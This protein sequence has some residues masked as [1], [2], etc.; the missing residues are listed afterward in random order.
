MSCGKNVKSTVWMRIIDY[1]LGRF[2]FFMNLRNVKIL[3]LRVDKIFWKIKKIEMI[4]ESTGK[5]WQNDFW[6][7]P[8]IV[9]NSAVKQTVSIFRVVEDTPHCDTFSCTRRALPKR[10]R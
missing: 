2:K 7:N 6:Q 9:S 5:I 8:L 1:V 10:S 3:K 4:N